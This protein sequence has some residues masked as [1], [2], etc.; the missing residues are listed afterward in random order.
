[1]SYRFSAKQQKVTVIAITAAAHMLNT[2]TQLH[3]FFNSFIVMV[4]FH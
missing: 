2:A 4:M 3:S 1:M